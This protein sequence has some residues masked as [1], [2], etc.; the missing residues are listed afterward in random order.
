MSNRN[1][2]LISVCTPTETNLIARYLMVV[3]GIGSFI[4]PKN[5]AFYVG[6]QPYAMHDNDPV[7]IGGITVYCNDAATT[8]NPTPEP[9]ETTVNPSQ[10]PSVGPSNV[11]TKRPSREP[12]AA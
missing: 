4:T 10:Q 9:T 8:A 7:G 3:T 1:Y 2:C 6:F 5:K 12:S 11:P